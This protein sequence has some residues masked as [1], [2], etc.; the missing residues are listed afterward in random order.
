VRA[1]L[2]HADCNQDRCYRALAL[3]A[4]FASLRW[5]KATALLR[6]PET[7]KAQA[8]DSRPDLG[9]RVRAGDE[10]RTRTISLGSTPTGAAVRRDLRRDLSVSS[11]I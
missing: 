8:R 5:G 9:L 6:C 11:R 7:I 1:A 4:T 10:N 2:T 3:L